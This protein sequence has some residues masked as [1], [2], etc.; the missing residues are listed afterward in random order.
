MPW[1]CFRKALLICILEWWQPVPP[2][3][4]VAHGTPASE[5]EQEV[6]IGLE[7]TPLIPLQLRLAF[8]PGIMTWPCS[9]HWC[10]VCQ[11]LSW[12]HWCCSKAAQAHAF[13]KPTC[14]HSRR[15]SLVTCNW[16]SLFYPSSVHLCMC[17]IFFPGHLGL[18]P[19][20]VEEEMVWKILENQIKNV[21]TCICSCSSSIYI[22]LYIIEWLLWCRYKISNLTRSEIYVA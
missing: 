13:Y 17:K 9:E 18:C 10:S 3:G 1:Q 15:W 5:K 20:S 7:L 4:V 22:L 11:W 2:C 8:L 21:L 19:H 16:C 6:K 12:G 14:I